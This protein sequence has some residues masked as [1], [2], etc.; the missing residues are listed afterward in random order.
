MVFKCISGTMTTTRCCGLLLQFRAM[1]FENWSDLY[2]LPGALLHPCCHGCIVSVIDLPTGP[3]PMSCPENIRRALIFFNY[4]GNVGKTMPETI[5]NFTIL[6]GGTLTM[7]KWVV[8]LQYCL[9]TLHL[10]TLGF[11]L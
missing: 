6:I 3:L 10:I 9:P 1:F 11:P 5:P 7:L 8:Y 4:P 2:Y